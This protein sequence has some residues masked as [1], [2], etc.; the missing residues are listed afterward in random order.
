M[1]FFHCNGACECFSYGWKIPGILFRRVIHP[2][3]FIMGKITKFSIFSV[4]R[5][6]QVTKTNA[7]VEKIHEAIAHYVVHIPIKFWKISIAMC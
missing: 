3:C 1:V 2:K 4:F 7:L 5:I 6:L